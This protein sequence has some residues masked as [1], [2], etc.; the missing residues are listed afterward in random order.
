MSSLLEPQ[1]RAASGKVV[2]RTGESAEIRPLRPDDGE[3]LERFISAQPEGAWA[4]RFLGALCPEH[5]LDAL[6]R[7]GSPDGVSL[8]IV[9]ESATGPELLAVGSFARLPDDPAAGEAAVIVDDGW[10][11]R[12]VG[13][14]LIERITL[15]AIRHGYTRLVAVLH[16]ENRAMLEVLRNIGFPYTVARIASAPTELQVELVLDRTADAVIPFQERERIATVASLRPLLY[17]HAVAV[18][19][20]SRSPGGIGRK[21]FDNLIS[22]GFAGPVYPVHPSAASIAGFTAYPSLSALPQA[23]DLVVAAVPAP[24]VQGVAEE[25]A[26]I[27]IPGLVVI[28]SGFSEEGAEGRERQDRLVA[29][30]RRA[31]I[32]MVGPNCLGLVNTQADV[33]MNASFGPE[34]PPPGHIAIASQSGALGL[35][36]LEYARDQGLGISSFVSLGNK[37][38]VSSN[39]LIQYWEQDDATR[40]IALYLESFGNPRRFARIARRVAQ[41]KPL[42]LVKAARTAAGGRAA[43]AHTASLMSNDAAVQALVEQTGVIRADTLEELFDVAALLTRQPLPGGPRVA[44]VTNAGGPGILAADALTAG[45]MDVPTPSPA[46]QERLRAT[47]PEI[48]SVQNPIDM[49][50]G[51]GPAQYRQ[52]IREVMASPEFDAVLVIFIPIE[53][54][55]PDAIVDVIREEGLASPPSGE[56]KPVSATLMGGSHQV[57]G[58][59]SSG[60]PVY[61]FPE[62][63]A[64]SLATAYRYAKWRSNPPGQPPDTLARMDWT[65][66]RRIV[67]GA[68]EKG[69]GWLGAG[70]AFALLDALGIPT[71]PVHVARDA[72]EAVRVARGMGRP[73]AVKLHSTS[74]LHKSDRGGVKLGL[75]GDGRVRQACAEIAEELRAR[76]ELDQL[77][78][79]LVQEMAPDGV[80]VL[81][82]VTTDPAFGPMV[83]F[84]LGGVQVEALHDVTFALPPLSEHDGRRMVE[85]IRAHAL[86]EEFRGRPAVDEGQLVDT[87]LRIGLLADRIPE[88]VELDLNPVMALP[89][90]HGVRVLDARI[91]VEPVRD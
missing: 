56:K 3:L 70:D 15:V 23:V 52:V 42:M 38:D 75:K 78:G 29:T 22:G 61:R 79:F 2:L 83:A 10:R 90:G 47:L 63:A 1:Y 73:V 91:R 44:I 69:A 72:E 12:G 82:G 34:P 24:A 36:L 17:P 39:D 57:L 40:V 65:R 55:N 62:S 41:Q 85:G 18:V 32:R 54:V 66:A 89:A 20:V 74:L 13:T 67:R 19:G 37:G 4:F 35:V 51:A 6:M 81:I 25:A 5:I 48:A 11:R 59:P 9:H 60:I 30:V 49:T 33:R 86:L 80:E 58:A 53:I 7:A 46:L 16:A 45:G 28:S 71:L 31:G 84:G 77:E 64:R 14:V 8:A 21:I 50:A 43:A 76:G 68:L 27:Q 87:L 26:R 88:V